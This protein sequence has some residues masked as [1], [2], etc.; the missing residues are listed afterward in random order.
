MGQALWLYYRCN[1]SHRDIEDLLAERSIAMKYAV[2]VH[3]EESTAYGVSVLDLP[4]CFSAGDSFDEAVVSALRTRLRLCSNAGA[5]IEVVDGPLRL[6]S[7]REKAV[8]R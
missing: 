6:R 2:V 7:W 3:H 8:W 1:L 4:G 5:F